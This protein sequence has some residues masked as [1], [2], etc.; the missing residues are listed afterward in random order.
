[1]AELQKLIESKYTRLEQLEPLRNQLQISVGPAFSSAAGAFRDNITRVL[2][3]GKLPGQTLYRGWFACELNA[4]RTA[5]DAMVD[6]KSLTD[7]QREIEKEALLV[8]IAKQ[9]QDFYS[10]PLNLV[11]TRFPV[12]IEKYAD[13]QI[14]SELTALFSAMIVGSWTAFNALALDLWISAFDALPLRFKGLS[15]CLSRIGDVHRCR[16]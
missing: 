12:E 15:G 13:F 6:W 4:K 5:E 1:V 11:K 9:W 14:S 2:D 8:R 16:N 7:D 10:L 3:P